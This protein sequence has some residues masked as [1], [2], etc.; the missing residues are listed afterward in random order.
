MPDFHDMVMSV[1]TGWCSLWLLTACACFN[2]R[3]A[4]NKTKQPMTPTVTTQPTVIDFNFESSA[5]H[6][7]AVGWTCVG[8]HTYVLDVYKKL[9]SNGGN[10]D[11]V[12]GS[13]F[14][15]GNQGKNVLVLGGDDATGTARSL[16]FVLPVGTNTVRFVAGGGADAPSGL[17]V[18]DMSTGATVCYAKCDDNS[19]VLKER[20]C[21]ASKAG[22]KQVYIFVQDVSKGTWGKLIIDNIQFLNREKRVLARPTGRRGEHSHSLCFHAHTECTPTA[23]SAVLANTNVGLSCAQ[24]RSR[25]TGSFGLGVGAR[26]PRQTLVRGPTCKRV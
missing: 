5:S 11:Y 21:D 15:K 23:Q 10:I 17:Y 18:K 25:I 20:N 6:G 12:L 19:D 22:G 16:P 9:I 13:M 14:Q 7:C 26:V 2:L 8:T 3:G 1:A 4:V 24:R